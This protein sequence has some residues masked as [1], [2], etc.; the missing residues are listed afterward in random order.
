M[1]DPEF[2]AAYIVSGG[3]RMDSGIGKRSA[4]TGVK[5]VPH[6][7]IDDIPGAF[8]DWDSKTDSL[9]TITDSHTLTG[10]VEK[11]AGK[12]GKKSHVGA[13]S[14]SK[15][16]GLSSSQTT[17]QSGAGLKSTL[18]YK[19]VEEQE[20][21]VKKRRQ[22]IDITMRMMYKAEEVSNTVKITLSCLNGKK[23]TSI[24]EIFSFA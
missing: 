7:D 9:P 5:Y 22:A 12:K 19:S 4:T 11:V 10:S 21:T 15:D 16:S 8:D 20:K 24:I 18:L 23:T 6:Y 2:D 17:T 1:D 13:V 3:S 14:S